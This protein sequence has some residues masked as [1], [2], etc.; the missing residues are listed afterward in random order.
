MHS[1][2]NDISMNFIYVY[3]HMCIDVYMYVCKAFLSTNFISMINI[4]II[5]L[6][7]GFDRVS[8]SPQVI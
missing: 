2:K 6:I 3:V 5:N 4:T 1:R 8:E 7:P